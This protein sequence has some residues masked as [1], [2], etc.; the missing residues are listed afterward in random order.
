MADSA[1]AELTGGGLLTRTL[2]LRRVL[3]RNVLQPDERYVGVLLPPSVGAVLA[4]AAVA[5]DGRIS[6]NLNYTASAEAIHDAI[7][8]CGIRHVLTS[9]R[10]IERLP[11]RLESELVFMEDLP[12]KAGWVDKLSAAVATWMLPSFALSWWFGLY[13][14]QM[15]DVATVIFTS[16]T[17]GKPKGVMLTHANIG[18]NVDA[19]LQVLDL[20]GNDV[21]MGVLPFF[22]SFGY[23]ATLWTILAASPKGVYHH[24][25]IDARKIGQLCHEH[26]AT[27]LLATPTFLRL[28][29]KRCDPAD[30]ASLEVVF[31]G[32]EK[33][34]TTLAEAFEQKFGARPYEGYGAT[35]LSP[36]ASGNLPANRGPRTAKQGARD[37]TVGR[38]MPRVEAK[39]IDL[40]TG[41]DLGRGEPGMLL[42]RGPNV[43]KGYLNRPEAT[44]EVIRDGWYV[45]GDVAVIDAD[46][47]I[48]ITDRLSR[49]SKIGGEMVP[50]LAVEEAI[51]KVLGVADDTQPLAVTGIPDKKKGERLI[52]VHTGL[53]KP[54]D[55]IVK[56]LSESGL[57]PLWIPSADSYVQVQELPVLGTGKLD[58]RRLKQIATAGLSD[59]AQTGAPTHTPG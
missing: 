55:Q 16:G 38:P 24:N 8:Q 19:I 27:I 21:V 43:M 23:T 32:A 7:A 33:L 35:E 42:I 57:P 34:P 50:H 5:I 13:R 4:N 10:L 36:I 17:T 39:V 54:A 41:M 15:D 40:E 26:R 25:P 29:L 44:A 53:A 58:L 46:G 30:L 49:F 12:D 59:E 28:Y 48:Q 1:G 51:M 45:T 9:R 20:R 37:G 22:H 2:I 31:V 11:F 14:V 6:V 3:V 47:F 52:V 56:E 18:S